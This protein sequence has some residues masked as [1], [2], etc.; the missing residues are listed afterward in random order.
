[1]L[2]FFAQAIPCRGLTSSQAYKT[3]PLRTPEDRLFFLLVYLTTSTLQV[4]PGR[5]FGMVQS[6][7]N[8]WIHVLLPAFLVALRGLGDAPARSL[9]AL[10][11]RLGVAAAAVP[12]APLLPMTGP[13]GASSVPKTLRNRRAVRVARKSATP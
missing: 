3:C 11:Q 4:V 2:G 10:A 9:A 8:Q 13:N 5:V 12:A 1:M 6:T 7:A